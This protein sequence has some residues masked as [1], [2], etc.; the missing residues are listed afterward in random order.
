MAIFASFFQLRDNFQQIFKEASSLLSKSKKMKLKKISKLKK[1][2]KEKR[3]I[4]GNSLAQ[5]KCTCIQLPRD[6]LMMPMTMEERPSRLSY[7]IDAI[8]SERTLS[9]QV[10]IHTILLIG[11]ILKDPK[12]TQDLFCGFLLPADIKILTSNILKADALSLYIHVSLF[13]YIYLDCCSS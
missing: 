9:S 2:T 12:V 10:N 4:F 7:C 6:Q 3:K 1:A 13:F 8:D 5:P 11:S